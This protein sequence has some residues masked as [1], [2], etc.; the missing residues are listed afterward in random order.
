MKK[1]RGQPFSLHLFSLALF[2]SDGVFCVRLMLHIWTLIRLYM[3]SV[4]LWVKNKGNLTPVFQKAEQ[5]RANQKPFQWE[6]VAESIA[7]RLMMDL[8]PDMATVWIFSEV[9]SRVTHFCTSQLSYTWKSLL[10]K[11]SRAVVEVL[12]I[13]Q[14]YRSVKE[15]NQNHSHTKWSCLPYSRCFQQFASG[16]EDT[17]KFAS[18]VNTVS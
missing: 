8:S 3:L 12:H 15:Q 13:K 17:Q 4:C 9:S 5:C 10:T 6:K 7:V 11:G 1:W 16:Y 14:L 18:R 2:P